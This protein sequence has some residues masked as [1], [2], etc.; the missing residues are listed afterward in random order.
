MFCLPAISLNRTFIL[1]QGLKVH[2]VH[3]SS[4][5]VQ[6]VCKRLDCCSKFPDHPKVCH[7]ILTK[8]RCWLV[9]HWM[10]SF[11]FCTTQVPV[12]KNL[13][14]VKHMFS[15]TWICSK[16]HFGSDRYGARSRCAWCKSTA[17]IYDTSLWW[18]EAPVTGIVQ[19][20]EKE[21]QG[22]PSCSLQLLERKLWWGR[23]QFLVPSGKV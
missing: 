20:E 18:G 19:L 5:T 16:H 15:W 3:W 13:L 22:G 1:F 11:F 9:G 23:H 6:W 14:K 17:G 12:I 8:P 4:R 10:T 2:K 7:I 21:A